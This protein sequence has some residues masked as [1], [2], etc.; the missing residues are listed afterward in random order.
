MHSEIDQQT[1]DSV[2]YSGAISWRVFWRAQFSHAKRRGW[3]ILFFP[4]YMAVFMGFFFGDSIS[5]YITVF[6]T[7][8]WMIPF[9]I[10]L[11]VFQ[12]WWMFTKTPQFK[13][14]ISGT[15]SSAGFTAI[16]PT[17][18]TDMTWPQFARVTD[19]G[20]S[21]LLYMTPYMFQILSREFFAS[22]QDWEMARGFALSKRIG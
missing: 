11:W 9:F 1:N 20:N 17:G 12:W 3:I 10:G 19:A 13:T 18:R 16:A 8:L 14:P 4:V 2:S 7:F 21:L 22:D 5:D 6:L 15:V